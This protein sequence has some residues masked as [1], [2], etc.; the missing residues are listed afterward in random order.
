MSGSAPV[1]AVFGGTFDPPHL[2]HVAI[3]PYLVARGLADWVWVV[4]VF[5]HV[6][7]KTARPFAVR[8]AWAKMAFR[9]LASCC[10]V[11]DVEEELAAAGGRGTSW[12]LLEALARRFPGVRLRLVVGSDLAT[13]RARARYHRWDEIAARYDP[14]V[15]PRASGDRPGPLPPIS[16]TRL[17]RALAAGDLETVARWVPRPVFDH[18]RRGTDG[19]VLLVGYGHAGRHLRPWL[20]ERGFAVRVVRA[21]APA[22]FDAAARTAAADPPAAVYVTV[23]DAALAAVARTLAAAFERARVPAEI[24]VLHAAGARPARDEDAL[25]AF[26]RRGHPVGTLHPICSLRRER[27]WGDELARAAFGIEGDP[28]AAAVARRIA[29]PN[30]VLDLS[31]LD[32][33]GRQAYHAACALVA[34]HLAVLRAEATCAVPDAL[35]PDLAC[36]TIPLVDSSAANLAALGP[37]GVSGP[38]A[39]GDRRTVEAHVAAL[40]GTVRDLYDLLSRRLGAWLDDPRRA[41]RLP[42]AVDCAGA[43]PREVP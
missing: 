12:E 2:G 23:G 6:W 34:N 36:A 18:L 33:R 43:G 25:G 27:P 8:H 38:L 39:R 30:R 21:R 14:I 41:E 35:A 37:R 29:G 1:H 28:A 16:S 10:G 22:T 5:R 19:W 20:V 7:G 11:L 32:A 15:V 4:P 9:P 24:P 31:G 42:G 3:P 17:R 26:A 40:D 13:A